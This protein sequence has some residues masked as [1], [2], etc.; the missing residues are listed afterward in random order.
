MPRPI[1]S[2]GRPGSASPFLAQIRSTFGTKQV[3]VIRDEGTDSEESFEVEAHI[4]PE[5]GMFDIET[6]IFEGDLVE[7][8]DPRR[9]PDGTERRMAEKVNVYDVPSPTMRHTEVLWGRAAAP[10]VAPVRRL[11]FENLHANVKIAAGSF[12]ADG[13]YEA[14][15]HEA[16]KS[17]EV[18]VQTMTGIDKSGVALMSEAFRAA[19]PVVDV[20]EHNGKSGQDER[21]GFEA[22]FR[23]VMLGIRNPGAH[24][25]FREGDPQQA[26]EYLG[27]ASLLHRR[28]DQHE[29]R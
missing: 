8:P 17:I 20:S 28:L 11:T 25:L 14:A 22:I 9:G 21:Q 15:V 26:L 18:R 2:T 24:E 19:E 5:R 1:R 4:Q 7:I 3:R 16:F 10:R 6:P 13:H 29:T 12:F 27:F 23:G